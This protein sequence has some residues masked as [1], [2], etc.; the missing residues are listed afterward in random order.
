MLWPADA[1]AQ[2]R[3]GARVRP[4]SRPVVVVRPSYYRPYYRPYYSGFYGSFYGGLF[5]QRYPYPYPYY[6]YRYDPRA[7]VRIDG[8]PKDAEVYVDGYFVGLVDDFDGFGQR[9]RLEAGDYEITLYH[10]SYRTWREQVRLRP[11]QSLKIPGVLE[12]LAAG[13]PA[14][15]RPAATD[16]SGGERRPV[17]RPR[18]GEEGALGSVSIRVQPLDADVW[19]D[20]ERWDWPAGESHLVVDLPEGRH[21]IEVRREGHRPYTGTIEVRRGEVTNLNVSLPRGD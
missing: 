8:A 10:P 7:E 3:R 1:Y 11:R 12:P 18:G 19:I 4:P 9:L 14:D 5:W 13:A 16:R 20:G 21:R 15:P 6:G 17:P 2:Q